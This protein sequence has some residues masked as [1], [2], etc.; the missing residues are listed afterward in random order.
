MSCGI[1]ACSVRSSPLFGVARRPQGNARHPGVIVLG[2]SEGGLNPL[3]GPFLARNGF[4]SLNVAYFGAPR[5]P[6]ELR[7]VPLEYF[8]AAIE[9]LQ[10]CSYVWP[11][12]LAVV[13]A[14]RG[15]ELAMLLG[16]LYPELRAVVSISG[17][18]VALLGVAKRWEHLY[19]SAWSW[20]GS[21]WPFVPHQLSSDALAVLQEGG[22]LSVDAMREAVWRDTDL[23]DA[24]TIPVEQINGPVLLLTGAEDSVWPAKELSEVATERLRR[25][26]HGFYFEHRCYAELG[27][28]M[29]FASGPEA[30]P[31]YVLHPRVGARVITFLTQAL[32]PLACI[33]G[34]S[35]RSF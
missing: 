34:E 12:R 10:R 11:E 29:T 8:N 35:G 30:A 7:E 2:G 1:D 25:F 15:G 22:R 3:L 24:A 32:H 28:E 4:V 19:S 14:S 9:W 5:L 26:R 6:A 17:S 16:S 23:L 27:H 33:P 13:G 18:G 21:P 20:R 31:G